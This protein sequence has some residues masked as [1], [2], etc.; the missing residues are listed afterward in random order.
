MTRAGPTEPTRRDAMPAGRHF[1]QIP[2]PTNVPDRVL[3]AIDRPT[4]DHRGPE[5]Q[6]LGEEVLAGIRRI[7]RTRHPVVI[8]PASGTG[9]WEAALVNVLSPGDKVLMYESG[10]FAALWRKLAG[11]LGLEVE[12]IPGD[13]RRG[14]E[15]PAIHDRLVADKGH[16]IKAVCV[17]HNETSTGATTRVPLVRKAIDDAR[18]PALLLVDTISSLASIDY[19][20]D[21]WGV[22][23]TV[24]GSQK[25]LM[26]P[27]GLSFN[28]LSDKALEAQKTARLPR[29]YW[30]WGEMLAPNAK[31]FFPYTPATNLLYGLREAIAM[32]EEE[33]LANVFA[34]HDRHAEATRRAAAAWGLEVLCAVP[35]E[36]SSS[37]TA[38]MMPAGHDAD[39]LRD[40]I[41]GRFD[42]SLGMGL[43]RLAG[44]V[45][46]I[47]HLG[48]FNDLTLMGTLAGV[49]M[50]LAIAGVPHRKGGAQAAMDYLASCA[51]PASRAARAA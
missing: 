18:H 44:K 46:R 19:R 36:Y 41:L 8:Y 45:F 4:I 42:M 3:R 11:R 48:D 26:L 32:L 39:R 38:L 9:A 10:H 6:A 33:G 20:H 34:R 50:G 7:F 14:A 15:A 40:A 27:P 29:S 28:A 47:G 31:G 49:E 22:D 13:W 37:L 43:G 5:F 17:V 24:G 21:E 35:E 12:L 51:L 2:G 23:V 1:L 25:G 30:D 16:S